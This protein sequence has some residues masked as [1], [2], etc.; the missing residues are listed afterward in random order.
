MLAHASK[1]P[2]ACVTVYAILYG[3]PSIYDRLTFELRAVIF[4]TTHK[5]LEYVVMW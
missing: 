3:K 2:I 1:I 4:C 5:V